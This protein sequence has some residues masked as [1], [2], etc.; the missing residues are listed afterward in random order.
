MHIYPICTMD[1]YPTCR[2]SRSNVTVTID[3]LSLQEREHT[4]T[5]T[6]LFVAGSANH[7]LRVSHFICMGLL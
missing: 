5:Q 2:F 1:I 3:R 7:M 4:E 6:A